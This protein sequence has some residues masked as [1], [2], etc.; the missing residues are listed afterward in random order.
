MVESPAVH[1]GAACLPEELEL[2]APGSQ[3]GAAAVHQ[4]QGRAAGAPL[5]IGQAWRR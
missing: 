5:D 4:D 1:D 3:V 2:V